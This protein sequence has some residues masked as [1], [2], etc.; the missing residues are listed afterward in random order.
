MSSNSTDSKE[1]PPESQSSDNNDA[2]TE[3]L[4]GKQRRR[5]TYQ[6]SVHVSEPR[7]TCSNREKQGYSANR[8]TQ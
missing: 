5:G 7:L 2:V 8:N 6:W 3:T 4:S 1:T